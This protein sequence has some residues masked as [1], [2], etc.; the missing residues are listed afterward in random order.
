M[1]KSKKELTDK[2]D[3][4]LITVFDKI[5]ENPDL[6]KHLDGKDIDKIFIGLDKPFINIITKEKK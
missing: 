6:K 5:L 3:N 2:L 1:K 4:Y